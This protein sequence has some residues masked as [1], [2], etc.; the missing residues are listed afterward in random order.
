MNNNYIK[1]INNTKNNILNLTK[2]LNFLNYIDNKIFILKLSQLGGGLESEMK[3][4][5]EKLKTEMGLLE[6]RVKLLDQKIKD[7]EESKQKNIIDKLN[8]F[9]KISK[10]NKQFDML[11][12]NKEKISKEIINLEKEGYNIMDPEFKNILRQKLVA[13][14]F[15]NKGKEKLIRSRYNFVNFLIKKYYIS[16]LSGDDSKKYNFL[17]VARPKEIIEM[18]E[19]TKFIN[20][21]KLSP[22][23]KLLTKKEITQDQK[24]KRDYLIGETKKILKSKFNDK[25]YN[26]LIGIIDKIDGKLNEQD[27]K[28]IDSFYER[29]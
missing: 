14:T 22:L 27:Q 10:L 8:E 23:E 28:I 2:Q 9:K 16:T 12:K 5:N 4:I 15:Q 17:D 26:D 29:Y 21:K 13:N 6:E 11:S 24:M 1:L 3:E 25:E 18:I 19:Y 20:D 7:Y